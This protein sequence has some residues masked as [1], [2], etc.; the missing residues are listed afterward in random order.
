MPILDSPLSTSDLIT[1]RKESWVGEHVL[2]PAYNA[3]V[4]TPYN[5]LANAVNLASEQ[6]AGTRILGKAELK[7]RHEEA[8]LLSPEWFAENAAGGLAA[9]VPYVVAGKLAGAGLFK[10]GSVLGFEGKT[11]A[12][13]ASRTTA[14]ISGAVMLD[15][16]R[17]VNRGETRVGNMISGATAFGIFAVANPFTAD[18]SKWKKVGARFAIG[19]TA[20]S[21]G[22]VG[23]DLVSKGELPSLVRL[24][25]SA[26]S[27]AFMNTAL[28]PASHYLGK[29]VDRAEARV[30]GSTP[31]RS[32]VQ[33]H[34]LAQAANGSPR[35][36]VLDL[37]SNE[38][39]LMKVATKPG[40]TGRNTVAMDEKLLEGLKSA[41]PETREAARNEAARYVGDQLASKYRHRH[42]VSE[43]TLTNTG[44]ETAIRQGRLQVLVP[45][46]H[47]VERAVK[48]AAENIGNNA[49]DI[50]LGVEVVKVPKG[51]TPADLASVSPKELIARWPVENI[52][53]E[54]ITLQQG[55]FLLG[56]THEKIVLPAGPDPKWN[57]NLPLL[58]EINSKS[59]IARVGLPIHQTA[60]VL[61]NGTNNRITLEII[62]VNPTP[63]TL[64][65]GMKI[66][67]IVFRPLSGYPEGSQQPSHFSGQSL[68]N[69]L[70]SA[71][72]ADAVP[73]TPAT[74][75]KPMLDFLSGPYIPTPRPAL[76][77]AS[78]FPPL[79]TSKT[80]DDAK[81]IAKFW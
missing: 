67:S 45:D 43:A 41:N 54:G 59:S 75:A 51:M 30:T 76:T 69:G 46:E 78:F 24:S 34:Q 60:P 2:N 40:S 57:G 37:F 68:P 32:F 79:Y 13:F 31:L 20:A 74:T 19:A 6:V 55:E 5:A 38:L 21:A 23:G 47:G 61:N 63:V 7:A 58:G 48:P 22:L 33:E 44:I 72:P 25:N 71:A 18:L 49:L 10:T 4:A 70:K 3:G 66:G 26:L 52:P 14:A 64:H 8:K 80:G 56:I 29:V 9:V 11:G 1:H 53:K 12:F 50:H 77:T 28:A 73:G 15:G 16:F 17:D 36:K 81:P 65:A 27:G 42:G 39:P 35:S 62:N